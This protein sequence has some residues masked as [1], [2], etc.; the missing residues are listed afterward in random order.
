MP[1]STRSLV[2]MVV[3]S[4]AFICIAARSFT[5]FAGPFTHLLVCG[6]L[7]L[8]SL[9]CR[10]LHAICIPPAVCMLICIHSLIHLLLL[11]Q[12]CPPRDTWGAANLRVAAM[13]SG[14]SCLVSSFH[15]ASHRPSGQPSYLMPT[16]GGQTGGH[17]APW[18]ATCVACARQNP[19]QPR[20][21][22]SV[23]SHLT[24]MPTI[25]SPL[26]QLLACT[27]SSPAA[28][29]QCSHRGLCLDLCSSYNSITTSRKFSKPL[30]VLCKGT[31][32]SFVS[33]PSFQQFCLVVSPQ[34]N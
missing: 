22:P 4:F 14:P 24:P 12:T 8:H 33:V 31:F 1:A 25:P 9:S 28:P 18:S 23:A 2:C 10:H 20:T 29:S 13:W 30:A 17:V 6:P 19:E 11:S 7:C 21:R 15:P 3:C 27:H 32:S 26:A 5:S 16:Q 34:R